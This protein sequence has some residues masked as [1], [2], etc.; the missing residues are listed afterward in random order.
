MGLVLTYEEWVE[1]EAQRINSDGC[2]AVPDW[3][4]WC[5]YEHDLACHYGKDPRDA[6]QRLL[7]GNPFYWSDA[8][9]ITRRNADLRFTGCNLRKSRGLLGTIRSLI[10]YVGVR[11]GAFFGSF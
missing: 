8:A 11:I 6:F 2:T 9:P 1:S 7:N 10:R 3:Q 4:V 5:C